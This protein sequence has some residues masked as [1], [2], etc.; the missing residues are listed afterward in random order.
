LPRTRAVP[1]DLID[2]N[3]TA[4]LLKRSPNALYVMRSRGQAPPAYRIGRRLLYSR[5]EVLAWVAEH[6]DDGPTRASA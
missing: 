3:E 4:E 1:D 6:R 2:T 5:S